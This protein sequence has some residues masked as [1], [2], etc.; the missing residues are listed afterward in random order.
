MTTTVAHLDERTAAYVDDMLGAIATH[1]P[2]VEA[3]VVGSG[4]AG[5]FDPRTSDVD[6]VAVVER[7]LGSDRQDI[8]DAVRALP[9]PV[10]D[11]E[12]VLYVEGAQP[13]GFE[14]NLNH[15]E[16]EPDAEPFWFVLDAALAQEHAVPLLRGRPWADVFDR[17]DEEEIRAAAR[18]SLA[19]S[20]QRDSEFAQKNAARTR[21]YF[22][23]REWISK[24][25]V[26]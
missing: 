21:H 6:V 26:A 8:I 9:C 2:L 18:E 17:M 24:E 25:D 7:A 10:R 22:E 4:A 14:L 12:L 15:G 16:E 23:H 11:L 20:E 1:V 3:Y 13:P 19:W 5:G